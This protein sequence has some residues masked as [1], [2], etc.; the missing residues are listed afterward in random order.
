MLSYSRNLGAQ[1]ATGDFLFFIDDDNV[2]DKNT[3]RMLVTDLERHPD[4]GVAMPLMHY[5]EYP[6]SVWTY[7]IE[8]GALPGFYWLRTDPPRS[9]YTFS[10]HNAF[11]LRREVFQKV[12]AFDSKWFPIHYSELDYTF[13]LRKFGYG[14]IVVPDAKIWHHIPLSKVR[15]DPNRAYYT[16]RNRLILSKKYSGRSEYA[17]YLV[18]ALLPLSIYYIVNYF[19]YAKTHRLSSVVNLINGILDANL[20]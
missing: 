16:L 8:K 12:G 6:E 3:I 10:F 20:K 19:V 17:F 18:Y 1:F 4:A 15:K 13:R 11:I 9:N 7:H 5:Y 14:A 2:V